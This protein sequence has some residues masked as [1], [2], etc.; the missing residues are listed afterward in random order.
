MTGTFLIRFRVAF[1]YN[2]LD[3]SREQPAHPSA[4]AFRGPSAATLQFENSGYQINNELNSFLV[5]LNSN[6]SDNLTNKFQIGYSVFNDFRNPLSTP[7]PSFTILENGSPYIIAG[8]EPFSINN[9][10]D[11]DV[12][13]FSNNLTYFLKNHTLTAGISFEKFKFGNS[14]N[15]GAYGGRGVFFP[16]SGSVNDFIN[17]PSIAVDL[18]AAIELDKNFTAAGEGN[19]EGYNWYKTDVGQLAFYLQDEWHINDNLR[20][21]LGIRFDKPM[22][23]DTSDT[24][25]RI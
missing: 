8:H 25:K 14:F 19:V 7:A 9:K 24:A 15:L 18:A 2:F 12:F 6:F 21:T 20:L 4:L 3:A 5:E 1:I 16:T 10:L 17:D 13:Q 23:F 22:Y 11:Q